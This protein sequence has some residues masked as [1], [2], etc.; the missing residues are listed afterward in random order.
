MYSQKD[1][2]QGSLKN[3]GK[4]EKTQWKEEDMPF[5]ISNVLT[6]CYR[7]KR[8]LFGAKGSPFLLAAAIRHHFKTQNTID[9]NNYILGLKSSWIRR[10]LNSLETKWKILLD[11][12]VS[13]ET[14]IKTGSE[15]INIV[16]KTLKMLSG[17]TH[18]LHFK[19]FRIK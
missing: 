9:I 18:L 14:L 6:I 16:K 11:K 12:I 8:V 7:F 10:I 15:Y 4:T 17:M 5:D 19:L 2:I 13:I 1:V 3:D